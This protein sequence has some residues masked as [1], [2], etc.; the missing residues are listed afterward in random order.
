MSSRPSAL[1]TGRSAGIGHAIATT[2][3]K[4]GYRV[5]ASA[6][7]PE[8]LSRVWSDEPPFYFEPL[9][10]DVTDEE[11]VRR[12]GDVVREGTGGSPDVLVNNAGYGL[13]GAVEDITAQEL[14]AQFETNLFGL[15]TVIR[16]FLPG[17]RH[18]GWGSIVNISS[19]AGKVSVPLQGAYCATKFAVEA[20]S[21]ALRMELEGSGVRV[22]VVEP[23]PVATQ[24]PQAAMRES[25][26]I[27]GL[28]QSAYADAYARFLH[29]YAEF[30][31]VAAKPEAVERVVVKALHARRPRFR[32]QVRTREALTAR[33]IKVFP[34]RLIQWGAKKWSRIA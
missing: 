8:R 3:A 20:Y 2:L 34:D 6:R 28:K 32:Y 10:L 5:F 29:R 31:D 14:R 25:A 22:I 23:G 11:S 9:T 18:R 19:L 26:R 21:D 30:P 27:L 16:E 33:V 12:A 17:M 24:F 7:H 4:E 1:V 13:L 15:H